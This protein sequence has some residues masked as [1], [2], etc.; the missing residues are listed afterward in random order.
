MGNKEVDDFLDALL[1][2]PEWVERL[3]PKVEEPRPGAAVQLA[4]PPGSKNPLRGLS[5]HTIDSSKRVNLG[6]PQQLGQ[7]ERVMGP[8][9]VWAGGAGLWDKVKVATV[10]D[11]QEWTFITAKSWNEATRVM[12]PVVW[13]VA[14]RQ[15]VTKE[16]FLPLPNDVGQVVKV[17]GPARVSFET[18]ANL[19]ATVPGECEW[20]FVATI[21]GKKW[22][23][24]WSTGG[25]RTAEAVSASEAPEQFVPKTLEE[26]IQ[27]KMK[28]RW[29]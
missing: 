21:R 14:S 19:I 3:K 16:V 2:N 6:V 12:G 10:P 28:K 22:A 15:P 11:G 9:E 4:D 27:A 24:I 26:R 8:A 18:R 20:E 25:T 13:H 7:R 1:V 5:A 29:G 23:W 17:Q